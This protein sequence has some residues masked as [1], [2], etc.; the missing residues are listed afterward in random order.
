MNNYLSVNLTNGKINRFGI[1]GRPLF[2]LGENNDTQLYFLDYS[3]PTNYPELALG[4]AFSEITTRDFNSKSLTLNAGVRGGNKILST[5]SF[6]N[7]PIN[8]LV[9][10]QIFINLITSGGGTI[11][12]LYGYISIPQIPNESSLFKISTTISGLK[13]NPNIPF[14]RTNQSN[15]FS[16]N[17]SISNIKFAF[18]SSIKTTFLEAM[19]ESASNF[20][21]CNW[22]ALNNFPFYYESVSQIS[23]YVFA[24]EYRAR[25]CEQTPT[26]SFVASL[27]ADSSLAYGNY[28]KYGLLDF[29]SNSWN[30]V[31]GNKSET[32]IWLEAM[33]DN[34]TICQGSAIICRKMT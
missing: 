23:D 13:R 5:N 31:I 12:S 14:S 4:D 8:I 21:G 27:S 24:F 3:V 22:N 32:P 20:S 2:I 25:T 17:D 15:L 7:L 10:T 11:V 29:S 34:Q 19:D 30:S 18:D 9:N 1:G 28:G 33:I 6:S 26:S 16:F